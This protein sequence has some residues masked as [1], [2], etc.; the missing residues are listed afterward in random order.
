MYI[1]LNFDEK[2][3]IFTEL[4]RIS[5]FGEVK[6]Q[7]RHFKSQNENIIIHYEMD[8]NESGEEVNKKIINVLELNEGKVTHVTK[9]ATI[10]KME[11][12]QCCGPGT[13]FCV[14]AHGTVKCQTQFCSVDGSCSWVDCPI[15]CGC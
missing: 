7:L 1:I 13:C 5:S 9:G 14:I 6:A 15:P 12:R 8:E 3:L 2:K 11:D 10:T 4:N